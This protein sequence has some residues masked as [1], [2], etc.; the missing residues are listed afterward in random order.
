[1]SGDFAR[2][3]AAVDRVSLVERPEEFGAAV[4]D[5]TKTLVPGDIASYNEVFR[6][7]REVRVLANPDPAE[8]DAAT[9]EAFAAHI[10]ENPLLQHYRRTGESRAL[11]FSDVVGRRELRRLALYQLCYRQIGVEHQLAVSMPAGDGVIGVTVSRA[12]RDFTDRERDLLDVASAAFRLAHRALHDRARA[13]A[14]PAAEELREL[15]L[16]PRQAEVLALLARGLSNRQIAAELSLS[17]HTV[18]HHVERVFAC[19]GVANR[20]DAARRAL[21][22][23]RPV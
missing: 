7:G 15:G 5:A 23:G 17:P 13:Q 8:F 18:D 9:L 10:E 1:M 16:T 21:G 11:R 3:R 19:L 14:A 12:G 2:L 20:V 4:L 6:G 22:V